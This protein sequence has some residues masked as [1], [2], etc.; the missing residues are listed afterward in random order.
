MNLKLTLAFA[1]SN[2]SRITSTVVIFFVNIF[3]TLFLLN[4]V[5]V[6]NYSTTYSNANY[7]QK[8]NRLFNAPN[9]NINQ[10]LESM[11]K[12]DSYGDKIWHWVS[13]EQFQA[14]IDTGTYHEINDFSNIPID[15]YNNFIT[16]LT[17]KIIAYNPL[18][19]QQIKKVNESLY[20]LLMQA[21]PFWKSYDIYSYLTFGFKIYNRASSIQYL[22]LKGT[23]ETS[24]PFV[25]SEVYI[26]CYKTND[27][28]QWI[29]YQGDNDKQS[30]SDFNMEND[31]YV[32]AIFPLQLAKQLHLKVGDIVI[33]CITN[34]NIETL[35]GSQIAF[36]V[37][38][39]N[40]YNY[41]NQNVIVKQSSI[42]KYLIKN[43]EKYEINTGSTIK[44]T[45]YDN[46][47]ND[48]LVTGTTP[49]ICRNVS[50]VNTDN[51]YNN[52]SEIM[53]NGSLLRYVITNY[54]EPTG[55]VTVI[56]S[57]INALQTL[58]IIVLIISV[59]I[60]LVLVNLMFQENQKDIVSLKILGYSNS[61]IT[62][63][64]MI[65]YVIGF[66]GAFIFLTVII[67]FLLQVTLQLLFKVAGIWLLFK[68]SLILLIIFFV[69]VTFLMAFSYI[70]GHC[71]INNNRFNIT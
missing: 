20:N 49:E 35:P 17:I 14:G 2:S 33:S 71:Q 58:T 24:L 50:F 51:Q 57:L 39:I 19:L 1:K 32:N 10:L 48:M 53:L 30:L 7:T 31:N 54:G 3:A 9:S 52:I 63:M 29:A 40:H 21:I 61:R 18:L 16:T 55:S 66:F 34:D 42:F 47:I 68:F 5:Y 23:W 22:T 38:G 62:L 64:I 70:L 41:F 12:D 4:F 28:S 37:S 26:I 43:Y 27:F 60:I 67:Y 8:G 46:F 36:R 44:I 59:V 56:N 13:N 25:N 69:S 45:N 15:W 11:L 65:P 6:Y